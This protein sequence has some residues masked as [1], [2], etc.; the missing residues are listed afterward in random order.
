[1]YSSFWNYSCGCNLGFIVQN[2]QLNIAFQ[3]I[4]SLIYSLIYRRPDSMSKK[5]LWFLSLS[6]FFFACEN[7]NID[8]DNGGDKPLNVTIDGVLYNL[9][10]GGYQSIELEQ[11]LHNLV[12]RDA[13]NE[14]I[15]ETRFTVIHG[16][17]LNVAGTD[18]YI[19]TDLYGDPGLREGKLKEDWVQIGKKKFFGDFI[20][21]PSDEMYIEKRWDYGLSDDFPSDLLGWEPKSEKYIIRS[22]LYRVD[23]LVTAYEAMVKEAPP[24]P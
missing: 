22:K 23:E 8:L 21:L 24:T 6:I 18:Y 16:G 12:I 5:I 4:F 10:P 13:N 11:G 20:L 17:L 15:K 7:G 14:G 3:V 9:S 19:W 1:M 2:F